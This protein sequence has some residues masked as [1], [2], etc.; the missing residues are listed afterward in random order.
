[1]QSASHQQ[2]QHRLRQKVKNSTGKNKKSSLNTRR[3]DDLDGS[4][5]DKEPSESYSA[6]IRGFQPTDSYHKRSSLSSVASST[7]TN[8]VDPVLSGM[9]S[10][11]PFEDEDERRYLS[12]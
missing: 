10:S 5:R 12:R 2:D 1:M 6:A 8:D 11:F 4:H 3:N 9:I 7:T